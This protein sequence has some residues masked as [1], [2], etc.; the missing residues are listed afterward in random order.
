MLAQS[1]HLLCTADL[2]LSIDAS[3]YR[4]LILHGATWWDLA[5]I[6]YRVWSIDLDW[7]FPEGKAT[8]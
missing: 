5:L 7:D 3:Y 8:A 2:Q 1:V 4:K 6:V